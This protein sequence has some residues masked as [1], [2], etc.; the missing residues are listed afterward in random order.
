MIFEMIFNNQILIVIPLMAMYFFV[1]YALGA[2]AQSYFS[3]RQSNRFLT[4][5]LGYV[6]WLLMTLFIYSMVIL[7]NLNIIWFRLIEAIKLVV[8]F[9]IIILYYKSWIVNKDNI[10]LRTFYKVPIGILITVVSI[11]IFLLLAEYVPI[12]SNNDHLSYYI[13]EMI[14]SDFIFDSA[15]GTTANNGLGISQEDKS[16]IDIIEN[17]ETFYYSIALLGDSINSVSNELLMKKIIP[18]FIISIISFS[19]LGSMVDSE[20][21]IISYIY[22][23]III[24]GLT[25][26]EWM[27]GT[28]NQLFYILPSLVLSIMLLFTYSSK[29]MPNDN[30]LI[31]S[32]VIQFSLITVTHFALPILIIFGSVTVALAI[33]KNGEIV[34]T[35]YHLV[36]AIATPLILYNLISLISLIRIPNIEDMRIGLHI[37]S[38]I[39][40]LVV[41]SAIIIPLRSLAFSAERRKDLISFEQKIKDKMEVFLITF[42]LVL[43][44]LSFL[45]FYLFINRDVI[46]LLRTYFLAISSNIYIAM[47]IYLMALIVPTIIILIFS[48]HYKNRT[49]LSVIP[50][51]TL[52]ANPMTTIFVF[53]I[54]GWNYNILFL[55]APE[56]IIFT[57]WII[58]ELIKMIP[59]KLKI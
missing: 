1:F 6:T 39:L 51:I 31:A 42:A 55:F 10:D 22:S 8:I 23:S 46:G 19:V 29:V 33:I 3:F 18:I 45:V 7:L 26:L 47:G 20:K 57:L 56:V 11:V 37:I 24:I 21:S 27:V 9:A 58:M 15:I 53:D 48:S 36:I 25:L 17:Y 2:I 44:L 52:I 4:I 40:I 50:V 28:D 54:V 38:I 12:S 43:T 30:L 35:M 13:N 41:V 49:I 5:P 14:S 32:L 16:T 34:K 59:D